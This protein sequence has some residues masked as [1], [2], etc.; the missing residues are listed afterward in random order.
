MLNELKITEKVKDPVAEKQQLIDNH[1]KAALYH[2][3]AAKHH[4]EAIKEQLAGNIDKAWSCG[5]K[6]KRES[7][8]AVKALKENLKKYASIV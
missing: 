8:L 1:K 7:K 3:M 6:A 4:E 5:I 2:E